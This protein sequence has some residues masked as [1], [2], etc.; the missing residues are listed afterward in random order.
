MNSHILLIGFGNMGQA[1]V[2]G[3]LGRGYVAKNIAVVD[4]SAGAREMAAS[5]GVAAEKNCSRAVVEAADVIVLAVKP[6]QLAEVLTQCRAFSVERAVFLSIVA[7]KTLR[8]MDELLGGEAAVVRVMPNTPAAIGQG[9]SV[10][11]ANASTGEAQMSICGDLM[12][13]VGLIEWIGDEAL[14]DAVTAVSGSGPAYVFLLIECLTRAGHGAG[15]DPSLASRLATATVAGAGA[16]AAGSDVDAEEL[17]RRVTS[18]NG[19]TEAALKVLQSQDAFAELLDE[20]VRAAARRSREL[21][22]E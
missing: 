3:W 20:A 17:R 5:L 4:P 18:P 19:T 13:A 6:G 16:Y 1:L 21:S 22:M 7:G 2:R 9:V 15:L 8:A 12:A 10:L 11:C 14:M